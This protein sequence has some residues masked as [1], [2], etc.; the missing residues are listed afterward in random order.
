MTTKEPAL[1]RGLQALMG[2]S[3]QTAKPVAET[4]NTTS[5]APSAAAGSIQEIPVDLLHRASYQPRRH[6]E[7]NALSE[8][9]DSIR[10]Q[11]ILQPIVVRKRA[12]L[13]GYEIIAGERRWRAAQQAELSTVPVIIREMDDKT[14][15]AVALIEN[16]QR[17]DLSPIEEALALQKLIMEHGLTHFDLAD[18]VNK[19]RATITNLLRLLNL[20]PE[21]QQWLNDKHIEMGHAKVLLALS[22]DQQKRAAM[23]VRQQNLSVRA[24]EQLVKRLLKGT[25][26]AVVKKMDPDTQRLQQ[27]LSE[28]LGAPVVFRD[29]GKGKGELIIKYHTLD[30]LGGILKHIQ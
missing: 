22:G 23:M 4:V 16:I 19:S 15:M 27:E 17:Q 5:P 13:S 9:A 3:L 7:P 24:T 10:A 2:S 1:K 28:K 6:F 30:E 8:L 18:L 26:P 20:E 14:A 11:G 12:G 25:T 21:I 29:L